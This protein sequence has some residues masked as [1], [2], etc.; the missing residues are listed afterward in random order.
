MRSA[1]GPVAALT[2]CIVV[3][4]ATAYVV[5]PKPARDEAPRLTWTAYGGDDQLTNFVGGAAV[6]PARAGLLRLRWQQRLDG[7][8]LASALAA[9]GAVFAFT[10]AGSVYALRAD[11]GGV[12][13]RRSFGDREAGASCGRWGITSTGAIDEQR[14][15]LYAIGS[16]GEL[17]AL[18][19]DDGS[20]AP[21]WPIRV[22]DRP[23]YEYV[24]SGL[25]QLGDVV[26]VPIASYCDQPDPD[27]RPAEGSVVAV[28]VTGPRVARVF[29][30]VQGPFNLGGPWGYGGVSVEPDGSFVYVALGNSDAFD[31]ECGCR[32]DVVGLGNSIVRLTPSLDVVESHRPA[33]VPE[34]GDYDFG[35]APLLFEPRGCEP[36]AAANNK[37]G[38]LYVWRRHALAAGPMESH[39]IGTVSA[40]FVAAPSW[41][42]RRQMVFVAGARVITDELNVGDGVQAF[43][44]DRCRLKPAWATVTGIGT[45][46]PPLIIGDVVFTVGGSRGG[47][48]ALSAFTGRMLWRFPTTVGTRAPPIAV[49]DQIFVGEDAGVIR[50]FAIGPDEDAPMHARWRGTSGR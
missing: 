15:L 16:D 29:D 40:P 39:P 18:S 6:T 46:P 13:W 10:E 4:P 50:A 36:L 20:E 47:F 8:V 26:Y 9:R 7:A 41:S 45:Q 33:D 27:G 28:D 23:D 34:Q 32:S 22:V 25:R 21:G 49:G 19:L 48:F 24:W 35:A 14:G 1:I 30:P 3:S 5:H 11:T 42:P 12:I 31:A 2:A 38:R 43:V 37:N 44:V 17:H